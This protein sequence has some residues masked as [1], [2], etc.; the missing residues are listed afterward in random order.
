MSTQGYYRYPTIYGDRVIFVSEDDLWT[1]STK[2][3]IARRLTSNLG[4]VS[5]PMFSPDGK[6]V[7]FI[8]TE[9]GSR[10]VFVMDSR[11]NQ[12]ILNYSVVRFLAEV[13]SDG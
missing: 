5:N 9:E 4:P 7:A 1:V 6:Q 11:V 13:R 8:G 10:E 12:G 3:G 2:G